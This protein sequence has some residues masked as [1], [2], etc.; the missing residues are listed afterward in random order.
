M[1]FSS[2][3]MT[4]S[5]PSLSLLSTA[6]MTSARL[7]EHPSAVMTTLI[8]SDFP[9]LTHLTLALFIWLLTELFEFETESSPHARGAPT[10]LLHL[11]I[12][13][14]DH[15]RMR[16]EHLRASSHLRTSA[17]SSPHA[18][19]ALPRHGGTSNLRGIIPACAGSTSRIGATKN[20]SRDHPRMR[21]EHSI[22]GFGD[23]SLAN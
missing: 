4:A 10:D 15:P 2:N 7:S 6:A 19:G 14:R 21:G 8:S 11:N 18:R 22:A 3:T 17:G 1:V 9:S 5:S 12:C 13:V 16:G 20:S 23:R